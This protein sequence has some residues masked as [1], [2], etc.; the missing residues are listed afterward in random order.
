MLQR[1]RVSH[2]ESVWT[3]PGSAYKTPQVLLGQGRGAA[4]D[5]AESYGDKALMDEAL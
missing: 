5:D 1:G 4:W 3:R 2:H